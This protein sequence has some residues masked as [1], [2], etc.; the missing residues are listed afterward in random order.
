MQCGEMVPGK[1]RGKLT[2]VVSKIQ[3]V[4]LKA[5][6]WKNVMGEAEL[7]GRDG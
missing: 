6:K 1:I 3:L 5:L 2:E 7:Q 4:A